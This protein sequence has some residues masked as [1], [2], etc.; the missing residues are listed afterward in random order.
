MYNTTYF[1][2]CVSGNVFGSKKSPTLPEKY[3]LG[4]S[5]TAP[6]KDGTGVTEPSGGSYQRVEITSLSEPIDGEVKN[7]TSLQFPESS[8]LWGD[9]A[10]Y[11]IFDFISEGNLL[12]YGELSPHRTIDTQTVV[13]VAENALTLFVKDAT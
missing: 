3:Y 9:M 5:S 6:S 10:Y 1:L 4:L 11:V 2:N 8:A 12:M 7:N 13:V